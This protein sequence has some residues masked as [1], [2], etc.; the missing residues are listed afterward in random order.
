MKPLLFVIMLFCHIVDDFYLQPGMLSKLKQKSW[1]EENASDKKYKND[2]LIALYI[3][4]FSWSFM[5]HLPLL[6]Y[7]LLGN[8]NFDTFNTIYP[9]S[10]GMHT[11]VHA[12]IDDQKANYKTIN[13]ITD[14]IIHFFQMI[15]IFGMFLGIS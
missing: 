3:H 4:G 11:F 2:Y 14:Q 15:V 6:V 10:L 12:A 7:A 1:W 5:V 13:L 8:V 9:I